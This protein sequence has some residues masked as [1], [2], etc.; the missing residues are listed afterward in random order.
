[1]KHSHAHVKDTM[2]PAFDE[3]CRLTFNYTLQETH[4]ADPPKRNLTYFGIGAGVASLEAIFSQQSTMTH[5][6]HTNIIEYLCA[7]H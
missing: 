1:M 3:L 2:I 5:A 4:P 6:N 7:L